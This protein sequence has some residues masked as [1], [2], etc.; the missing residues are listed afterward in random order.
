[1]TKERRLGRGLEALLGRPMEP[2]P[3]LPQTPTG[4][5][6]PAS[7]SSASVASTPAPAAHGLPMLSVYDID[8]N[9]FQPRQEFDDAEIRSLADSIVAHGLLQPIVVRRMGPRYQL[10]A[11]ERRLRAAIIAGLS[12]VPAQVREV[13]E[14]GMAEIALV[15]NLQRRDLGALE[16]AASFQQYLQRYV[17]T[18]EE[19][20]RRLQLDRST[21]AN[22][23]RLLELPEGVQQALR[24]GA[25]TPGHARALL[26]LGDEQ[27]QM[28]FA[29][30]IEAE[31]LSVR[32]TEDDVAEHI[33]HGD[34]EGLSVVRANGQVSRPAKP[35]TRS[36][37][38]RVLEQELRGALGVRVDI[39]QGAK[40]RGKIVVHFKSHEEFERLRGQL[41]R[42]QKRA[43]G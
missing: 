15:E 7:P 40:G 13:N 26:P 29:K 5:A 34:G 20:A 6:P 43:A 35:R 38:Q 37:H 25:I 11:G 31:G 3:Y 1:M 30:R 41:C 23:I 21:V 27:E 22:L 42:G 24:R 28:A 12:Q 19:L 10:V 4:A 9:P 14:R 39:R 18:Q 36:E 8:S 16:K 17:C 2:V 33:H 32:Q